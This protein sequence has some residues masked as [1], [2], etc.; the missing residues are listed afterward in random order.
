MQFIALASTPRVAVFTV[1]VAADAGDLTIDCQQQ[2]FLHEANIT[3]NQ[4]A[5]HHTTLGTSH[6]TWNITLHLE[7]HTTLGTV[8]LEQSLAIT[9]HLEQSN[10][11][12]ARS[13]H[14]NQL[15]QCVE[16]CSRKLTVK[17]TC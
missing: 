10:M 15:I 3:L 17:F 5:C 14:D 6:Y 11:Q 13:I 1:Q 9:L 4:C 8:N 16:H 2:T 7:H 12:D